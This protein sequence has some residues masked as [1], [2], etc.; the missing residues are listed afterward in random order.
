MSLRPELEG[1]IVPSKF[2][3][4]AAAG[5]PVLFMGSPTGEI[6]AILREHRCGYTVNVGETTEAVAII[7]KLANDDVECRRLG[8][9]ARVALEQHYDRHVA[10][11]AW[12]DTLAPLRRAA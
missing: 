5:R 4:I 3:G 7:T 2:Y 6:A 1:L 8:G 11:R 9:A 12:N 10:F